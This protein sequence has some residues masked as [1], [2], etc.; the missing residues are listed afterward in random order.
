[1]VGVKYLPCYDWLIQAFCD[2]GQEMVDLTATTRLTTNQAKYPPQD[3]IKQNLQRCFQES[4]GS[5]SLKP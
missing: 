2:F 1:L 4:I 3:L 5:V